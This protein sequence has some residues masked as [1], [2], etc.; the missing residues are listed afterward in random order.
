MCIDFVLGNSYFIYDY[1]RKFFF[2]ISFI[3]KIYKYNIRIIF[4]KFND[5]NLREIM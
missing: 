4:F 3:V 2:Y 1:F 5:E